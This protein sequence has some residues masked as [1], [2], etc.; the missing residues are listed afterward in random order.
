MYG[1]VWL[2]GHPWD[3]RS[4]VFASITALLGWQI[5]TVFGGKDVVLKLG[6]GHGGGSGI[7]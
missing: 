1:P 7:C 4:M 6:D 2:F 3:I 5:A